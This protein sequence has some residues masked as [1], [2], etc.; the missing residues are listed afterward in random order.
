ADMQGGR[1]APA[2][3]LVDDVVVDESKGAEYLQRAGDAECRHGW[4]A[5]FSAEEIV[6]GEK[7]HGAN[8]FAGLAQVGFQL[9]PG[10]AKRRVL[11]K[12]VLQLLERHGKAGIEVFLQG[13][14]VVVGLD[15]ARV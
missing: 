10:L 15:V 2:E 1:S 8:A 9:L 3:R 11:G 7:E 14:K 13:E 5:P 6:A 12:T 4:P